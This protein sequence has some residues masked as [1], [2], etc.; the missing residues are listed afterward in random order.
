MGYKGNKVGVFI[1]PETETTL[2]TKKANGL[3]NFRRRVLEAANETI[4]T[5]TLAVTSVVSYDIENLKV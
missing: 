5:A 3:Y 1:L 2:D 4:K